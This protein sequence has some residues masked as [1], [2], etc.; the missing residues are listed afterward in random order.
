MS[1]I[2]LTTIQE[3]VERSIFTMLLSECIDKGYTPSGT[4]PETE[5]GEKDLQDA[6]TAINNSLGYSIEIFN[7]SSSDAKGQ[8]RIPRIVI[9]PQPFVEGALGGDSSRIYSK[10]NDGLYTAKV[11][12]PQTS[13]YYCNIHLVTNTGAQARVLNALLSLALP[14]RGYIPIYNNTSQNFFIRKL[15]GFQ[16]PDND[17]GILENVYRFQV[18]DIFEAECKIVASDISPI[19][20]ITLNTFL[21][22]GNNKVNGAS[23]MDIPKIPPPPP[24]EFVFKIDT[25]N[26]GGTSLDFGLEMKSQVL[27]FI[28]DW[29][30]GNADIIEDHTDPATTHN[31]ENPGI[32]TCKI[33]GSWPKP[34]F[35]NTYEKKL[36]EI[37]NWGNLGVTSINSA[38]K[39]CSNLTITAEDG[40]SWN[41]QDMSSAFRGCSIITSGISN[42]NTTGCT[43]IALTFYQCGLYNE[44]L[45]NWDTSSVITMQYTFMYA[46]VFNG[47]VS[48]WDTSS[49]T[50]MSALFYQASSFNQPIDSWDVSSV[51]TLNASFYQCP[52]NHPLNSWDTSS[53]TNLRWCFRN[54]AYNHPLDNWDTSKVTT[55]EITFLSSAFNHP[56]NSWDVSSVT[57]FKS[58][59]RSSVYNYPLD[60]WNINTISFVNM[61]S[62]FYANYSFN[63]D[64]SS[65]NVSMVTDMTNMFLSSLLTDLEYRANIIGWT[66]WLNG[67]PTR[68]VQ[69]N[70][71]AHFGTAKYLIGSPS[72]EVR[73]YLINNKG[74]TIADGGGI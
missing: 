19:K 52:F 39:D 54:S 47:N 34:A 31:Y 60:N 57:N 18:P 50:D 73:N 55:L 38:F 32:Y 45:S 46:S 25:T 63:Q 5:Q 44:D 49:V 51:T 58:T 12:P 1:T 66:G 22:E 8:K 65:W 42:F 53:L 68:T 37:K 28:I 43:N 29:G 20:D 74:W 69:N 6:F 7:H 72:E 26:P 27:S 67:A 17:E 21:I 56:L 35:S 33:T 40:S 71:Q 2:P 23:Q 24:N 59:F 15:S 41:P 62:M 70:V 11:L 64:L 14:V 9:V 4:F 3:T 48:N 16:I 61:N 13:E 10:G 36:I 30:D